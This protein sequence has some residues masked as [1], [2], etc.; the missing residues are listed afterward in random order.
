[1]EEWRK[2]KLKDFIEFNPKEKVPQG[3]LC[4][5]ISMDQIT[6]FT[7]FVESNIYEVYKGGAKFRNYDTIMARITP[8]LENGKTAY[9][10]S[11]HPEEV[12]V[13]STEYIVLRK[14]ENISDSKFIF[15][16][17]ISPIVRDIAIKSMVGSSGR[18][19]VQQDVLEN[20]EIP[21][22]SLPMQKNI[23][24]ILSV[25]D[26][27][28]ELNKRINDN[29]EQQAQALFK[30]WFVDFEP[31][32]REEFFKSDSLFGDIPVEWHIV[33]IKDLSVY[34]TDYVANGS[35]ASL[36]E[37]VRLYDKPNYA[38]FI[39]NTDLKTESYKMYVDKHSYEFLSK[40]V[41][42]GGEIIISNVG[43]VGSVFLC[44][45]LEKPMTLGNNIILL[46]PKKDYLTFYLYMLFKGGI[47][48]HLIDGV[49]GGS[50]QRKFNKTDFKSI[51]LMMPPVNILIKFDRIIKP[52]FSKIE[53]NRDEISRLTS[54][55][56]TLLPKLM[57]GELKINDINN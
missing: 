14:R 6:P 23:A 44:P 13:G 52:I 2:Y 41:L 54:L 20:Y 11:L 46:R 47:G 5:K 26:D 8:C 30:S 37:N 39:R 35:F 15:Y 32:L 18:Q 55:R 12:A 4:R 45:K 56:D 49:T 48:Q 16:L 33:A 40:S 57:S 17:A 53:E 9:I 10:S 42:E 7:R 34:I 19:R 3:E 36:R 51:K 21:I 29:L 43:D 38:H 31:F 50:A 24:H 25:L 22:P 1:M 28:I 27:K